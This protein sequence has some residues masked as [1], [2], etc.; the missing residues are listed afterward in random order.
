MD[1]DNRFGGRTST[2]SHARA[3]SSANLRRKLHAP[4]HDRASSSPPRPSGSSWPRSLPMMSSSAG[5]T[6]PQERRAPSS[7]TSG[8]SGASGRGRG[9]PSPPVR[10]GVVK[11]KVPEGSSGGGGKDLSAPPRG[12][13]ATQAVSSELG[14]P[15]FSECS[16]CS[17]EDGVRLPSQ[18]LEARAFFKERGIEDFNLVGG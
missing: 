1:M 10:K 18:F 8:T 6:D 2:V 17:L 9:A 5:G 15:H 11:A 4:H 13:A 3:L 7:S 12:T 14:C 16:G